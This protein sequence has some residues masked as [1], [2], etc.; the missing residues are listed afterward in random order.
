MVMTQILYE[1]MLFLD[2][3]IPLYSN[4]HISI[5]VFIVTFKI[6]LFKDLKVFIAI[7]SKGAVSIVA[8][9]MFIIGVG[10]YALK[11]TSF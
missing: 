6:C 3:G 11:N 4:I 2:L 5:F 9:M 10:I 7:T 8:L 1:I